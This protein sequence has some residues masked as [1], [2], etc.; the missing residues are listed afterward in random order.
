M[1]ELRRHW[2]LDP[3]ITFLNHGSFGACPRV[4]LDHQTELRRLME[5]RPVEFLG[6]RLESRLDAARTALAE[7][8]GADPA[9]LAFV[10]N[11]TTGV[12]AI[13]GSL[14]FGPGDEIVITDHGYN[15]VRNVVDH[16]AATSDAVVRTVAL[17]FAG[18][19]AAGAIA[20]ITGAVGPRTR[21]V[22]VDHITSPTA[23]VLPVAEIA[24]LLE[25]SGVRVLVDG[26]HGPG[27][28]AVDVG[29]IGASY[30]VGNCH[31]WMCA[32][33]GSGFVYAGPGVRHDLMPV[34]I[35]HGLNSERTDRSRF[36]QLFD[37]VGTTDPTAYLAVPHAIEFIGSLLPGGWSA[38][39]EHNRDLALRGR[40]IV[41]TAIG[42]EGL[43]AADLIGS[44]AAIPLAP[45]AAPITPP[46]PD[47]LAAALL[48]DHAIEVPVPAWPQTPRRVLRISAQLYNR[49]EDYER[50]AT[51]LVESGVTPAP[52]AA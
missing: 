3:G 2:D 36:H 16:V 37:W 38:A 1:P 7:F 27:M 9:G 41:A 31:K 40:E 4:V 26:A 48:R 6:R 11:A 14:P 43:P 35:S 10:P 39:R 45:A 51:A 17:P 29:S 23:L 20:A 19:S 13:V 24:A 52:T 21:L 47:P 49:V 30:Y 28:L 8:V 18:I 15:A 44:M 46:H 42:A 34:V 33:K 50:L 12:N 32:P 25:G 5:A 22:I